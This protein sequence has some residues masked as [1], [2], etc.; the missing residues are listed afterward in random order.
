[1]NGLDVLSCD[2]QN[3]YLNTGTKEKNWF[4]AGLEMG[5]ANIGKPV[6]TVKALY[7]LCSS[8]AMWQEHMASTLQSAGFQSCKADPDV[9]L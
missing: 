2:V 9:W 7:G 8:G 1:L 6:L 4:T 3:A 5:M